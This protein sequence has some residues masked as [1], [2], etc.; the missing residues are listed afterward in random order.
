MKKFFAIFIGLAVVGLLGWRIYSEIILLRKPNNNERRV[1]AVVIEVKPIRKA[2]VRDIGHFTGTLSPQAQ[3][4][5]APKI[6]GRL[7]KLLVNVGDKVKKGQLIALLDDDEYLQQ[8]NQAQAELDVA[9]AQLEESISNLDIAYREF[10][11]VSV[12]REKKIASAS[13]LDTA[14]A[15][16]K[17]QNAKHKVAMAQV[18]EKE[19]ALRG[20]RVRL[21]YTRI[22]AN[23]EDGSE[24]RVIGERFMDEGAML[25]SNTSIVSILDIDNL[26][27]VIHIIER[28][29]SKIRV[30]QKAVITTDAFPD[31]TF[32][33]RIIRIAPLLKE[34]SRQAR[35]ELEVPNPDWILKPGMFVRVQIEFASHENATII[36]LAALARRNGQQ[37]VFV[38]D[39]EKMAAHFVPLTL[40]IVDNELAEVLKPSLSGWVA[41]LGQH[42]LVE[43]SPI[44]LH[45][46]EGHQP[47]QTAPDAN[48]PKGMASKKSRKKP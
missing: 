47:S 5:V 3:F 37:G 30:D 27:G 34:T 8:V 31:K 32:S 36:P 7:E 14:Q 28:D 43:G 44:V 12:L 19:A 48:L 1:N 11:R 17:T 10:E 26:I 40:G 2:R 38:I 25:S 22:H 35:I 33:G 39:R 13:E 21:S 45:E 24:Y 6:S 9:R 4:I 15:Q 20:V 18:A 23:W 16:F 29:Y 41:T 46:A 42:L